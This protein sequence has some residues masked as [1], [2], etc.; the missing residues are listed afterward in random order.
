MSIE[1]TAADAAQ[2]ISYVRGALEKAMNEEEI[3]A[4]QRWLYP[5]GLSYPY[6]LSP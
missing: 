1:D 6:L 2:D 4:I 3:I 5:E